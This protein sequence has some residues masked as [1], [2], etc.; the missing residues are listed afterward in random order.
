MFRAIQ[1][2][3]GYT[4]IE[5]MVALL[6]FSIGI[7]SAAGMIS[8]AHFN[9]RYAHE[10]GIAV[11]YLHQMGERIGANPVGMADGNYNNVTMASKPGGEIDCSGGCTPANIA[12]NDIFQW[13]TGLDR[14]LPGGSGGI[15]VQNNRLLVTVMWNSDRAAGANSCISNPPLQCISIEVQ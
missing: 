6:V 1:K 13:Y 3:K 7:L 8:S 14:D 10:Y 15:T 5:V 4:L 12:A 9:N 2:T 11:H